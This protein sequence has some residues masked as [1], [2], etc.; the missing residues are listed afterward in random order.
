[1]KKHGAAKKRQVI[2]GYA[3]KARIWIENSGETFLGVGRV[4]LLERI[5]EYGS[6]SAAARS[7]QMSYKHA[8]DLIDSMNRQAKTPLVATSKGGKGGGGAR[9]TEAG[10]QA[11]RHFAELQKKLAAFLARQSKN[12]PW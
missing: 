2:P 7:M 6:I 12:L 4:V 10:E 5:R 3:C 11:T 9:L 1:M 8:W